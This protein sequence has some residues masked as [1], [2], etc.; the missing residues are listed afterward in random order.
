MKRIILS[1][2]VAAL[3]VCS[4]QAKAQ[5]VVTDPTNLVQNIISA[6][7]GTSTAANMIK[8]LNE[9]IKI[10]KQGK[11]YYDALKSVHS[12][13]KD[14][15]KVKLTI[16]M[17][18]EITDIYVNGF[19]KMVSD[20]NFS[21]DELTAISTGYAK[22]LAEGGA[23]VSDLKN[24]VTKGNGLSLSDKERMDAIDQI[25]NK[26]LE[27]RNLTKYYTRKSISVSYI[28]AKEKND[29]KRVLALYG[30]PSERY[31]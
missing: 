26:M 16:E 14:A 19:N 2:L 8:N 9:S 7:Q 11:E 28:R 15:R 30:S 31:W 17:V 25:Y 24:I 23:L 10:Y 1:C 4:Y 12:L 27:Y 13:I 21:P 18:S 5:W 20:P 6:V 22:L 3:S 29:M